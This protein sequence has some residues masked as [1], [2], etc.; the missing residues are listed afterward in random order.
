MRPKALFHGAEVLVEMHFRDKATDDSIGLTQEPVPPEWNE[1]VVHVP[2]FFNIAIA[3]N[4]RKVT[5]RFGRSA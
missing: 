3:R 4:G 1:V 5:V 2:G